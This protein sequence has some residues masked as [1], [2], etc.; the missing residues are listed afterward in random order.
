MECIFHI[1]SFIAFMF[2]IINRLILKKSPHPAIIGEF[3]GS[4]PIR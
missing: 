4:H 1:K 2:L 3:E